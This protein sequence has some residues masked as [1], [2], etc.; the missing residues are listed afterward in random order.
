MVFIWSIGWDIGV[1][2]LY[3]LCFLLTQHLH[4]RRK[5]VMTKHSNEPVVFLFWVS[6]GLLLRSLGSVMAFRAGGLAWM[7]GWMDA[8]MT[9]LLA[10]FGRQA[11]GRPSAS[12]QQVSDLSVCARRSSEEIGGVSLEG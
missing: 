2:D 5:S 10:W 1:S 4:E 9:D 6:Y 11:M 12:R 8:W 7:D 3:R